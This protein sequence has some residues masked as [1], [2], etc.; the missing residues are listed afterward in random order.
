IWFSVK[1]LGIS[2]FRSLIGRCFALADLADGLLREAG[3]FEILRPHHLS[4]VCFRYVPASARRD[5]MADSNLNRLNLALVDRLRET[6]RA[7]LSSTMLRDRVFLRF[8]FVNWR[9]TAPDVKAIVQLLAELA[10]SLR[11]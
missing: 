8:C 4:I 2:W 9:T 5:V 11:L 3:C 6:Q 7:F 10:Q 1:T